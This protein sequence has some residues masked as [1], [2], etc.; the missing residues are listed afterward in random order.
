M[1][2]STLYIEHHDIWI[3]DT[4]EERLQGAV[5]YIRTDPH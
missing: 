5:N 4:T 1:S 2:D 3:L